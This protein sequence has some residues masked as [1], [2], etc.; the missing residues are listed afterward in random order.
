MFGSNPI[1]SHNL[2][3]L[4]ASSFVG[5]LGRTTGILS[6]LKI[7]FADKARSPKFIIHIIFSPNVHP[8]FVFNNDFRFPP[9]VKGRIA[10]PNLSG[11][12]IFCFQVDPLN[13]ESQNQAKTFPWFCR[14]PQIKIWSKSVMGVLSYDRTFKQTNRDYYFTN[15]NTRAKCV[16]RANLYISNTFISSLSAGGL[17]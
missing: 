10:N 8:P 13:L 11:K 2:H 3:D 6:W 12:L 7:Y 15:I 1:I 14:V 5:E 16:L 17:L 4:F 9:P